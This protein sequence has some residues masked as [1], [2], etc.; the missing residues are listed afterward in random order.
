MLGVAG[1]PKYLRGEDSLL[2]IVRSAKAVRWPLHAIGEA[3][4]PTPRC[5]HGRAGQL[6]RRKL[7]AAL[8][9]FR[10]KQAGTVCGD[11]PAVL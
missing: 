2:S 1:H 7:A 11:D 4:A 10:Q 3:G 8:K 6:I 5:L 9:A